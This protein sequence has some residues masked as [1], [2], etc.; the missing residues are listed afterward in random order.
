MSALLD[1]I[2]AARKAKAIEYEDYLKRIAA[3]AARV[4]AG[5]AEDTPAQLNTPGLR[6]LFN[7]LKVRPSQAGVAVA[8]DVAAADTLALALRIDGA[9]KHVRFDDW[10]GVQ[11]R[12]ME[13]KAAL[14]GI[15]LDTAEVERI[16]LIIR[17]QRE[18]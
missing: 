15:L 4:Q 6:A 2:I 7:N 11:A 18:Y 12:E 9:V 10:R 8:A 16:F 13:I 5:Q 17:Q 3:L 1:E 14:Y